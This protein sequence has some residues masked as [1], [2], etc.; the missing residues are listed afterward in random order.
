[1]NSVADAFGMPFRDPAWVGK[2]AV[3]GLI[4]IIPIV[5]WIAAVG[6]LMITFEN[7]RSGRYELAPAG[8]HLGRGIGLFVVVLVYA[9]VLDVPAFIFEGIGAS[10]NTREQFSGAAF[11]G[12]G[13][14]LSFLA[15]LVLYFLL[16]S[17]IVSTYRGGFSGGFD[18]AGVWAMATRN[19]SS[20][21]IAGL[22]VFVSGIIAGLGII[23]CCIGFLFTSVYA[24]AIQAGVAAWF[25]G[26]QGAPAA[27]AMPPPPPPTPAA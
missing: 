5:G 2:I 20:S 9:L 16:P 27:P 25:E 22:I 3:Q 23:A 12:F 10:M 8:F 4:F 15:E 11:A 14:L 18:V 13:N 6:W 19:T 1:M 24:A 7:Y 26:S 21:V 17:L